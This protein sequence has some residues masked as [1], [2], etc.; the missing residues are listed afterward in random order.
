MATNTLSNPTAA[1]A[2]L[3]PFRIKDLMVA[4]ELGTSDEPVLNYIDFLSEQVPIAT[5]YFAHVLPRFDL[6][7]SYYQREA[8]AVISNYEINTEVIDS[9]RKK[10][11][12]RKIKANTLR[13]KLEVQEGNPL[14][15]MLEEAEDRHID[16][17]VIG[18][19]TGA[20]EHGI[21]ARNLV[22]KV[23]GNALIVPDQAVRR[24]NRIVVPID[25]S[26]DS[27][28]ALETALEMKERLGDELEVQALH[29][30]EMP[31]LSIYKVQKTYDKLRKMVEDDRRTAF[32]DFMEDRFPAY[33]DD[34]KFMM[35]EREM[36]GIARYILDYAVEAEVDMI[37]I[38]AKGHSR[39]ERLL[40]GSV[41]EKLVSLNKSIPTMIVRQ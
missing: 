15:K 19:H 20:G 34:V 6:Y 13:M 3:K 31:N 32:T 40:L 7:S 9:M 4:L 23:S 8:S 5:A 29:V 18:Q 35:I 17:L 1:E 12:A 21:L 37:L 10:L 28:R 27:T 26:E 24:L 30:Y 33:R 14:E 36:P 11:E 25:F 2:R 22:R 41:T 39:V 16:L 38:G